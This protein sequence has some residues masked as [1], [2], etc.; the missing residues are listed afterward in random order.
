MIKGLKEITMEVEG[1]ERETEIAIM[2]ITLMGREVK[3]EERG[4]MD[5]S[6]H[7]K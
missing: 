3:A 6:L 2:R 7:Q 4:E 5:I 1:T